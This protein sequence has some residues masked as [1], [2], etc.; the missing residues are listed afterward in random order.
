MLNEQTVTKMQEMKLLGMARVFEELMGKPEHS[1]LTHDEFVGLLV[2]AEATSRENR[3]MQRL[4]REAKLKQQAC[5]ED[6]DYRQPRGL[7]KQTLLEL[8]TCQWLGNHQNILISG[9]TGT[10]KTFIAC[11]IGNRVCRA[12]YSVFYTRAPR[13]FNTLFQARADGSYLKY[14]S[15]LARFNLMI[16]DDLG[17][18]PMNEVERKDF[19]EIVEDRNLTASLIISSQVPVK[20]WYQLIGDPTIADAICDRLLHNAYKIELKGESLRKTDKQLEINP[21]KK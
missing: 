10:G 14:L 1:D 15:K 19:L 11:A 12:G 18:S 2:D 17:L 8:S 16:I 6:I 7:H 13:L 21:E 4:L 20:D 5:L 3:K 9:A